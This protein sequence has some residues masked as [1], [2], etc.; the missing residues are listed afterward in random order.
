MKNLS[1]RTLG[2]LKLIAKEQGIN[3]EGLKRMEI[4]AAIETS[5]GQVITSMNTKPNSESAPSAT[6]NDSGVL[7]SPQPEKIRQKRDSGAHPE[8]TD[9]DKVAIFA[10]RNLSWPGVGK[11]EK[12]YNFVTREAA[13]KWVTHRAVRE[14]TPEE[15]AAHFGV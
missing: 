8:S 14:A 10:V 3:A 15:V 4:V 11:V 12:G 13:E 1:R 6:T 5:G 7:I 9:A 2:E